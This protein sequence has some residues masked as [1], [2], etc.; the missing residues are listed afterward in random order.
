MVEDRSS[1]TRWARRRVSIREGMEDHLSRV[2]ME[3]LLNKEGMEDRIPS[4][5]GMG[6]LSRGTVKG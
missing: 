3:D 4:K 5:E 6:R 1:S 2:V